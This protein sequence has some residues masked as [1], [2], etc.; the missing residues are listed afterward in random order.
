MLLI[1]ERII[2]YPPANGDYKIF[3]KR[4]VDRF[5]DNT[6]SNVFILKNQNF[7]KKLSDIGVISIFQD[8]AS[9]FEKTAKFYFNTSFCG[10][11]EKGIF[12]LTNRLEQF[13]GRSLLIVRPPLNLSSSAPF[14]ET[15]YLATKDSPAKRAFFDKIKSLGYTVI[16]PVG[17]ISF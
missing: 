4:F 17:E 9:E 12:S 15:L 3:I 11:G 5:D 2:D 13:S 8:D 16:K 10:E 1:D 7:P 14:G 6:F